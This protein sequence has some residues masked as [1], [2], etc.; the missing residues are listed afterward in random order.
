[1]GLKLDDSFWSDFD[2]A[3]D[4]DALKFIGALTDDERAEFSSAID[5][6]RKVYEPSS[7]DY[8]SSPARFPFE[9]TATQQVRNQYESQAR[10]RQEPTLMEALAAPERTS[11]PDREPA[12]HVR[13]KEWVQ[14]NLLAPASEAFLGL[15][16][17]SPEAP[18]PGGIDLSRT[19][20]AA[21][22]RA[23]AGG[24]AGPAVTR[25]TDPEAV[26]SLEQL[27][28]GS[29]GQST[30]QGPVGGARTQAA[31][32]VAD[33]AGQA[34]MWA[35]PGVNAAGVARGA[36]S[37][38]RALK[39]IA[40]LAGASAEGA[41]QGALQ[42]AFSRDG[43]I[44]RNAL[45][46][47]VAAPV[48]VG[49]AQAAGAVAKA[50]GG[51]APTQVLIPPPKP[52]GKLIK[53]LDY[54]YMP[55]GQHQLDAPPQAAEM[56]T[57]TT[58][59][60]E[61]PP[62]T[63][64]PWDKKPLV[65]RPGPR[66]GLEPTHD[67]GYQPTGVNAPSQRMPTVAGR[68]NTAKWVEPAPDA[69]TNPGV[70]PENASAPP[71]AK[72]EPPQLP[73][74]PDPTPGQLAP[75]QLEAMS[76]MMSNVNAARRSKPSVG[77]I[78]M[79]WLSSPATRGIPGYRHLNRELRAARNLGAT[80]EATLA[81][82]RKSA[83]GDLQ[84]QNKFDRAL[85]D[86][87][88]GR[89]S[90]SDVERDFP[91]AWAKVHAVAEPAITE[92]RQNHQRLQAMGFVPD[93]PSWANDPT[94]SEYAARM[95]LSKVLPHDKAARLMGR[96]WAQVAPE[97]DVLA[98][99]DEIY[100]ANPKL[101]STPGGRNQIEAEVLEML[102]AGGDMATAAASGKPWAQPFRNL[103]RREDLPRGIRR[104]LG[105]I[106][107]GSYRIPRTLGIQR[108]LLGQLQVLRDVAIRGQGVSKVPV[109][110]PEGVWV[111]APDIPQYGDLRG[112]YLHPDLWDA[113]E[114][115]MFTA[116]RADGIA[117]KLLGFLKANV[118]TMGGPAPW[119]HEFFGDLHYS[120]L[121]G[122]LDITR[123]VKSGQAF[124]QAV[125]AGRA[126]FRNPQSVEGQD[127]LEALRLGA[128]D[129]GFSRAEFRSANSRMTDALERELRKQKGESLWDAMGALR[130]AMS[131]GSKIYGVAGK[132]WDSI[133][134]Y[135]RLANYIKLRDQFIGRGMPVVEARR[136]AA[137]RVAMSFPSPHNLSK[138]IDELRNSA[139]G[140]V[141]P[142]TT[143]IAEDARI[144]MQLLRRMREEPGLLPRLGL[145]YGALGGALYGAKKLA[146]AQTGITDEEIAAADKEVTR[147]QAHYRPMMAALPFRDD[148][149]RVQLVDLTWTMP[150]FRLAQ[151]D[152]LDPLYQRLLTNALV[153]PFEGGAAEGFIRQG[154]QAAGGPA[155]PP[156]FQLRPGEA[157]LLTL[158]KYLNRSGFG[159]PAAISR[160][161]DSLQR[162]GVTG[163]PPHPLKERL[164][165]GQVAAGAL[166]FPVVP[167]TVP[168][169]DGDVSPAL[170]Q[171]MLEAKR[172]IEENKRAL[173]QWDVAHDPARARAIMDEIARLIADV[174]EVNKAVEAAKRSKQ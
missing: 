62:G 32:T 14:E 5:A 10:P 99:L 171:R 97:K 161:G 100:R 1:M 136:M 4:D 31:L 135:M 166:G 127:M 8:G 130:G 139:V 117:N 68:R 24:M 131:A 115:A 7:L 52:R 116:Q 29:G 69:P 108:A 57:P 58:P 85:N 172:A 164:T 20:E 46:G 169:Q 75:G 170:T 94:V 70:R 63:S 154:V 43:D 113:V 165:G 38:G 125:K 30:E 82:I 26:A 88:E 152:P 11:A 122:G 145:T 138:G 147:R 144:H 129:P 124:K 35:I 93:D 49:A 73:P 81:A 121:S 153:Y 159:G 56:V 101:A 72:A 168:Q 22:S 146:Q 102:G 107:S 15:A 103:K 21:V 37:G 132:A 36:V 18:M 9:G 162:A 160:I 112:Q 126:Y 16:G 163:G 148:K 119:V 89:V 25:R 137:D 157:G 120:I 143:Y 90:A 151:G 174:Q 128:V 109:H 65:S 45:I 79:D 134:I 133:S 27:I 110:G 23:M 71:P 17:F 44:A 59:V 105:E 84:F 67:Y 28:G 158:M 74:T 61:P 98:G 19:P 86:L 51:K 3:S 53:A 77:K 60:V 83:G 6:R 106:Q 47:A 64:T 149:G 76:G 48:L 95:Y 150:A 39:T 92:M 96:T 140:W 123:P 114:N 13:A 55:D 34:P 40:A 33:I 167:V 78:I 2:K 111:Q 54:G 50:L 80:E 142:F 87:A 41:A 156:E 42:G 155:A 104:M 12:P 91:E 118:T 141:A 173:R 66:E